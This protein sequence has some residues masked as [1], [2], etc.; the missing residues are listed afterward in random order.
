MILTLLII[1]FGLT[2]LLGF[3]PILGPILGNI[4]QLIFPYYTCF[5]K[6]IHRFNPKG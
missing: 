1:S 5:N 2:L 6:C 3:I 4:I